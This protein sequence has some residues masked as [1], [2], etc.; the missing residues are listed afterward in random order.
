MY[1]IIV[2]YKIKDN[3]QCF[4]RKENYFSFY[5]ESFRYLH[6]IEPKKDYLT[7]RGK[8]NAI[9]YFN[10]FFQI[11]YIINFNNL[12]CFWNFIH[13]K[14]S[15]PSI[16]ITKNYILVL[17]LPRGSN[18][19]FPCPWCIRLQAIVKMTGSKNLNILFPFVFHGHFTCFLV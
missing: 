8:G 4:Y 16:F 1:G 7:E 14:E 12:W 3:H 15:K 2:A 10:F 9:L 6:I 5:E 17:N 11:Y 19:L 13:C 18:Q